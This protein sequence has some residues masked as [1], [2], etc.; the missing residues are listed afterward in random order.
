MS[1]LWSDRR[2]VTDNTED[3]AAAFDSLYA[4]P[5]DTRKQAANALFGQQVA[6]AQPRTRR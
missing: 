4:S 1:L 3:V 6:A 5:T 2:Y